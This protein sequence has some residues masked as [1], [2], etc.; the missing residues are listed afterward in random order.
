MTLVNQCESTTTNQ[1]E[2]LK[3]LSSINSHQLKTVIDQF[4]TESALLTERLTV[5]DFEKLIEQNLFTAIL[6]NEQNIIATAMLWQVESQ[7]NWYEMGTVWVSPEYRGKQLGHKVFESM[8]GKIPQGSNAFLLTTSARV[9]HSAQTFGYQST[10][11]EHFEN[12][13]FEIQPP[14]EPEHQLYYYCQPKPI[15]T[16][17]ILKQQRTK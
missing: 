7:P 8:T 13:N 17:D 11:K 9:I 5:E 14:A 16:S 4:I 3:D 2:I 6:D 15:E 12:N 10:P 1:F